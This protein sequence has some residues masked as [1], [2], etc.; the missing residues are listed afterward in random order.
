LTEVAAELAALT[1]SD[2]DLDNI[3]AS[4]A[5]RLHALCAERTARDDPQR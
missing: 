2:F 5:E 3:D 4:G 1:P